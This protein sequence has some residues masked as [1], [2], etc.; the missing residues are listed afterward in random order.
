MT[1]EVA[2]WLEDEGWDVQTRSG[3]EGLEARRE[4]NEKVEVLRAGAD[5]RLRYTTTHPVGEEEFERFEARG[6]VGRVVSRRYV[7][8]T[9]VLEFEPD[10]LRA[11]IEVAL[12]ASER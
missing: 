10:A 8:T 9:V 3:D 1:E 11:S 4:R 5:A 2:N 6:V 7:E 12:A